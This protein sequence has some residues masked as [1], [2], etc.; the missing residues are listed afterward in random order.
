MLVYSDTWGP[1]YVG[2]KSRAFLFSPRDVPTAELWD[3]GCLNKML[4]R[5]LSLD[6]AEIKEIKLSEIDDPTTRD[7]IR[8]LRKQSK[9]IGV[10]V[11]ICSDAR[12][13]GVR[14]IL[15]QISGV[16][17]L[18]SA[19]NTVYA[20]TELPSVVIGHGQICGAA[21]YSANHSQDENPELPAIT[22][23]VDGDPKI[24][25]RK[26]LEKV[27]KE[28]QAGVLYFDHEKCKIHIVSDAEY[29]R[30][31]VCM[32]L[33]KELELSLRERYTKEEK[34]AMAK[35]QTPQFILLNNFNVRLTSHGLFRIDLQ[36]NEWHGIIS[37]SL[38]F[39]MQH[40]H[41]KGPTKNLI[42]T[43]MAFTKGDPLPEELKTF[44][45]KET[46][47]QDYLK[48]EGSLYL[49][50]LGSRP[51]AKTVYRVIPKN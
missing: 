18:A 42:P 4:I 48:N 36:R 8:D 40:L 17:I 20:P 39:A 41:K 25:A 11:Y 34:K 30:T 1:K 43:I 21:D 16:N 3:W 22:E 33:H 5:N 49:V 31:E 44:L 6:W 45:Q 50:T 28:W 2:T 10:D 12:N 35:G 23:V 24:N 13:K 38:Q 26:Q 14:Q 37:D 51:S 19:G 7:F 47:V 9:D 32:D 46:F 29:A 27:P 15:L